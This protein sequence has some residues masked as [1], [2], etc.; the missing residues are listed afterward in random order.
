MR[1]VAGIDG[2]QS[3]TTAVVVDEKGVV[4]GRGTAGPADHVGEPPGSR[5]FADACT[6]ALAGALAAAGLPRDTR[7]AAVHAGLSGYDERFDGAQPVLRR[8]RRA[9][10][11]RCAGR[12]R[13]RGANAAC[14]RRD[15]GHRIGR[16]R[17]ERRRAVR[18]HRR[19]G[20]SLRRRGQRVRR[21]ARRARA[22][23]G[24]RTTAARA[25]R[26]AT[27]RSH[28]SMTSNCARSRRRRCSGA[29]RAGSSHRS[30]ASCTTPRGSATPPPRA[31]STPP[32]RRSRSSPPSRSRACTS[33]GES[34][35]VAF[36]G[37]A[38]AND[39]FFA[40]TRDRLAAL[41]PHAQAVTARY[42][43]AVGAALLAFRDAGLPVPER[44]V[45]P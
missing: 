14:G 39:A 20:L 37:G 23:D 5:K 38:F 12:A 6:T 17:Q 40:R 24:A 4:R 13:G 43:P 16:V 42:D 1:Y 33:T 26:S 28:T 9:R 41:A 29:S 36:A 32:R 8:R 35:P 2:G 11:A 31:S 10:R 21:R 15:R 7:F 18:A 34:V 19:L 27:R 30:R 45:E 3:S 44:I 25:A 22:R